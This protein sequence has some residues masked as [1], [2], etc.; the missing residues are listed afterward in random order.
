MLKMIIKFDEEKVKNESKYELEEI[1][2]YIE[3]VIHEDTFKIKQ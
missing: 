1:F 2:D 3:D